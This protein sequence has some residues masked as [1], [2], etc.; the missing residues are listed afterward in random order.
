M[1][2]AARDP[3]RLWGRARTG[4]SRARRRPRGR[5]PHGGD[6]RRLGDLRRG[7]P[8]GRQHEQSPSKRRRARLDR[9]LGHPDGRGDPAAATAPRP[10][11]RYIGGGVAGLNLACSG[12]RT[13][14]TGTGSGQDLQAGHRLL[15]RRVRAQG[16]GAG[17]SETLRREPQR[18]AVV[19]MIGANNYGFG[20]IVERCVT[21]WATSPSWWKN[22]CSDDSDM[23]SRFTAA[24]QAQETEN[25][26]Q[27]CCGSARR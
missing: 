7:R 11:R 1:R 10:R 23:T 9:L 22:Y 8:L 12:A 3:G 5:H 25:V 15:L 20:A 27:A 21:N 14:T 17:C 26:R 4:A 6:A 18:R 16:P 2:A 13:S 19:V 24:R